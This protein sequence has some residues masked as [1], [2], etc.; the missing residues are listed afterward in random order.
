MEM[1]SPRG[2]HVWSVWREGPVGQ[3]PGPDGQPQSSSP[4]NL[5]SCGQVGAGEPASERCLQEQVAPRERVTRIS[6]SWRG[7]CATQSEPESTDVPSVRDGE[8]ESPGAPK[9]TQAWI[10]EYASSSPTTQPIDIKS[11]GREVR[12]SRR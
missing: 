11:V 10:Q 12:L 1:S 7:A 9:G 5:G 8:G 4:Q 2:G 6:S 3:R